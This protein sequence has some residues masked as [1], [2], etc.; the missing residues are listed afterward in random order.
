MRYQPIRVRLT[1]AEGERV[2]DLTLPYQPS[3]PPIIEHEG[4]HFLPAPGFVR[5]RVCTRRIYREAF[6]WSVT[7]EEVTS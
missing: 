4:R 1:S 6:T 5:S 7:Q 3:L 2:T